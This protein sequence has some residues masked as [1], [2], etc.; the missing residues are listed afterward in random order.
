MDET[1]IVLSMLLLGN[2][3]I[4][5]RSLADKLGLSVNAVHK[6]IQRLMELGIIR[7]FTARISLSALK[8]FGILVFG[9]SGLRS[10]DEACK[11]LGSHELTY[12]VG[13][14]GANHLYVAAYL[15]N[16]SE[17]E[18]YVDYVKKEAEMSE[19]TVGIN[20]PE[21]N[22]AFPATPRDTALYPLDYQ[23]IYA[24]HRNS[25]R[26]VSEVAEELSVSAKT[27]RR[28][29]S[30]MIRQGLI[31]LSIQ[32]YPDASNDITTLFHLNLKA[33]ADKSEVGSLLHRK[34]TPN[35][36]FHW[37][38]SN[39]PNQLVCIV[40]TNTMKKLQDIRRSLQ[41]EE[42]LQSVVPNVLYTGHIFDTW[43]DKLL[44][45]KGKPAHRT[46]N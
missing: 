37:S 16:I 28:R 5:Y 35:S 23:I 20:P 12:W 18:P 14:G 33:S 4:P 31:E 36:L 43:R 1:D 38:F 13:V 21:T 2:S 8:A 39:L 30:R 26:P 3:R 45:E 29:L 32:W 10:V 42:A 40:W 7:T 46:T 27:V 6:R 9:R 41:S 34:Y 19:P 15:Q 44:L 17:L 22:S 24:L 11:K 25:R